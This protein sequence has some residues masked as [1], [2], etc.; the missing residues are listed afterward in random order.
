[1]LHGAH[2]CSINIYW[3]TELLKTFSHDERKEHGFSSQAD[4]AMEGQ[5][6]A[7]VTFTVK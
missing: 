4:P 6:Q 7:S 3:V 5:W 1:M 2:K